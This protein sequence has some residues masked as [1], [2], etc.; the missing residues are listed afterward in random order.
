MIKPILRKTA[1]ILLL[2]LFFEQI[3]YAYPEAHPLQWDAQAAMSRAWA[4]N[5]LNGLPSEIASLEDAHQAPASNRVIILLQDAHTNYSAQTA[6]TQTLDFLFKKDTDLNYVFMEA[7]SGDASLSF[8]RDFGP[9][10]SRKRASDS[11]LRQGL[12]QAVNI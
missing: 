11:L 10:V 1:L 6:I 4:K 3:S 8:L 2:C 12:L 7:A 5:Y 9:I